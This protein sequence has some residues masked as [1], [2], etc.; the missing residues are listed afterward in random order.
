[1]L[2]YFTF[3]LQG[4]QDKEVKKRHLCRCVVC[5]I[6]ESAAPAGIRQFALCHVDSST[7]NYVFN[8]LVD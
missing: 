6:E 3:K 7:Y 4:V 8:L 1:M 2:G 5:M